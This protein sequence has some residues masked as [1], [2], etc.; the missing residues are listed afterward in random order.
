MSFFVCIFP[1]FKAKTQTSYRNPGSKLISLITTRDSR[2][3]VALLRLYI[4][5]A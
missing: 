2:R 5:A 1:I 3:D 4:T